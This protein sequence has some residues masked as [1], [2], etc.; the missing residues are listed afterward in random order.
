MSDY[1]DKQIQKLKKDSKEKKLKKDSEEKKLK[2]DSEDRKKHLV[3]FK[4]KLDKIRIED[5]KYFQSIYSEKQ[6]E[7]LK[8]AEYLKQEFKEIDIRA[9]R[10]SDR[11][12]IWIQQED[13]IIDIVIL[14]ASKQSY[15][16][17]FEKIEVEIHDPDSTS[18]LGG[19]IKEFKPQDKDK[20]FQYFIDKITEASKRI[21]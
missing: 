14:T 1:V 13:R 2:K 11:F 10:N 7:F 18:L 17:K 12:Q 5:G 20:A 6:E 15:I 19:I 8:L 9:M 21:E 16:N 4:Q 3:E